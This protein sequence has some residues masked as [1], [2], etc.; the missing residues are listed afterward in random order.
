MSAILRVGVGVIVYKKKCQRIGTKKCRHKREGVRKNAWK[1]CGYPL[2]HGLRTPREEIVFTARPKIQSQ[3]QIFRY[4]GSIFCLPHRPNF[5]DIFD[6]C[7]HWV[8]VVRVLSQKIGAD[9]YQ[10]LIFKIILPPLENCARVLSAGGMFVSSSSKTIK[11][12]CL[13]YCT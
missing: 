1:H 13:V 10:K 9:R 5:S 11:I 2:W 12:I 6:L 4:G 3:S 7:L 8:S